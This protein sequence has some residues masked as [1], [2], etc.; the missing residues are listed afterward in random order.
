MNEDEFDRDWNRRLFWPRVQFALI[1]IACISLFIFALFSIVKGA[2][3]GDIARCA[4]TAEYMR[5]DYLYDSQVGCMIKD[6]DRFLPL[7]N[8]K[9]DVNP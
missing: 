6:G 2:I 5:V 9:R 4:K 8:Y 1:V 3:A 7:D